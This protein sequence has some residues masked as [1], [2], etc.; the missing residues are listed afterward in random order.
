MTNENIK[1]TREEY[2]EKRRVL[3]HVQKGWE[4]LTGLTDIEILDIRE[5]GVTYKYC[6]NES[7]LN[8]R[9]YAHG[10]FLFTLCDMGSGLIMY[11]NGIEAV[12]LNAS[13]NYLYGAQAGDVLTVTGDAVHWGRSTVVNEVVITNQDGKALTRGAMTMYVMGELAY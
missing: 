2:L 4:E 12:T 1:H 5:H 7:D 10:G 13:V 11:A 6:V 3:E 8:L 9:S